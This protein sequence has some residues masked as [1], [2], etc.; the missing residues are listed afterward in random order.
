VAGVSLSPAMVS[1]LAELR[2]EDVTADK[3]VFAS[4]TG[5]P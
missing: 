4:V 1:W 2:P 3:P 5:R